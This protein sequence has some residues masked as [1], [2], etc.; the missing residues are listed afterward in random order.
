MQHYKSS[1]VRFM[2]SPVTVLKIKNHFLY[3]PNLLQ[4]VFSLFYDVFRIFPRISDDADDGCGR[5]V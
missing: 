2:D 5:Y 4:T 3:F 1:S